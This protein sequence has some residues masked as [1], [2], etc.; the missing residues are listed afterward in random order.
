MPPAGGIQL[1]GFASGGGH[2]LLIR[3]V[4]GAVQCES[5]GVRVKDIAGRDYTFGSSQLTSTSDATRQ[6]VT[7]APPAAQQRPQSLH[8]GHLPALDGVRGL[9][10]L[11]VLLFH[12]VAPTHPKGLVDAAITWLFAY[13][14]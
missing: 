13:G 6:T 10:I 14:A 7:V 5:A 3:L 9:A 2:R 1:A 8:S 12:F 11:A 4:R